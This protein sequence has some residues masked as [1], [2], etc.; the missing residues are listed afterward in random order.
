MGF[1]EDLVFWMVIIFHRI[2]QVREESTALLCFERLTT[3][4]PKMFKP[5]FCIC[6]E[7]DFGCLHL[8]SSVPTRSPHY[9][10][11][12]DSG[13]KRQ[14]RCSVAETTAEKAVTEGFVNPCY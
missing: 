10:P 3:P 11:G 1:R 12:R 9:K 14:K 8:F 2:S 6:G 5:F 7:G 13:Q 4:S